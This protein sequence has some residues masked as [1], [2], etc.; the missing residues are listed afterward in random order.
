MKLNQQLNHV[1]QCIKYPDH[2]N[3]QRHNSPYRYDLKKQIK[4]DAT[5]DSRVGSSGYGSLTQVPTKL[6]KIIGTDYFGSL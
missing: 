1:S 5:Q 3:I 6:D 4:T 2:P